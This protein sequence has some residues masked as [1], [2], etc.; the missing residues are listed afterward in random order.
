MI[1]PDG[2]VQPISAPPRRLR[3]WFPFK[4]VAIAC[5]VAVF[6]KGYLIWMLGDD[7]Y[8]LAVA[9]LL[10]GNQ[11]QRAAGLVL[12]PDAVS[13]AAVDLY[14]YVYRV[15]VSVATALE[16]ADFPTLA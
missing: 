16:T 10:A 1:H 6:V 2:V 4:G 14:Q 12:L 15:I 13:N 7:V 3:F 9:E 8:G 11:F 5:L